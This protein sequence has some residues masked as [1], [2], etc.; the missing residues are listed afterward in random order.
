M[1]REAWIAKRLAMGR[2]AWAVEAGLSSWDAL[3]AGEFDV[4]SDA[5]RDL[6]GEDPM[7]VADWITGHADEMPLA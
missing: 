4:V 1:E 2:P 3:D 5:V 7:T 6:T